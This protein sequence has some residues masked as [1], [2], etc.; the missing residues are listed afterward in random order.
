MS[1]STVNKNIDHNCY[2][3]KR[4]KGTCEFCSSNEQKNEI[5]RFW[6]TIYCWSGLRF[7]RSSNEQPKRAIITRLLRAADDKAATIRSTTAYAEDCVEKFYQQSG[8]AIASIRHDWS[9]CIQRMMFVRKD[10]GTSCAE[11]QKRR[12]MPIR[13]TAQQWSFSAV[14]IFFTWNWSTLL[15][16]LLSILSILRQDYSA[17][18]RICGF[19]G[20]HS[21]R[22]LQTIPNTSFFM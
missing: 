20:P 13:P 15:L 7:K 18:I 3:A 8:L 6:S 9:G 11:C 19:L 17:K 21:A 14:W 4:K 16:T 5:M 22:N 10:R 12:L 2:I 1:T